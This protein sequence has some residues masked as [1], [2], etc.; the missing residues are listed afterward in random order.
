MKKF[1]ISSDQ[2]QI[3][4]GKLLGD[5]H[6]ETANG[7]TWRLKIEHS[8]SQQAYVDWLYTKLKNLTPSE[9]K[10][11]QQEVQGRVYSKYWFN[12]SY[13]GSFRFYGQQF[14]VNGRKVVPKQINRWLTPLSL[15]VWYMDDGSRKSNQHRAKIINTQCFDQ[16]SLN[17]LQEALRLNFGIE[18]KLRKQREGW[19]IYI[20]G[21]EAEK[22]AKVIG[23]YVLPSFSYKLD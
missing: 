20:F 5:G 17:R 19:Q 6:L 12:T 15:A 16:I 4:V 18:T 22:F 1:I 3:I 2:K 10:I 23:R 8:L 21:R 7:K 9:P 13:S 11:K 14:Y